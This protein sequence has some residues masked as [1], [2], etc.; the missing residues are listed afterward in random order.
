VEFFNSTGWAFYVQVAVRDLIKAINPR[1]NVTCIEGNILEPLPRD[2]VVG[3]DLVICCTD[4]NHSRTAVSELAYRYLVPAIDVGVVFESK[5][6]SI[7]GEIGRVTFYSPGGPCA[8]CLGL[9]DPWR[10]TVELMSEEEKDCRRREAKEA[11][12]RGDDADAYWRDNPEIPTVGHFTSVVGS[13]AASYAI[14][15][16]TGKFS[17]PNRYFE[18]NILA[19]K[20]DYIGFDAPRRSGCYCEM[21]VGHADQGA[22]ASLISAPSHWPE[23]R[24]V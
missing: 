7:T 17:P 2:H 5:S 10:A 18:F 15:W 1:A 22:H 14:G 16:L 11:K 20:F 6:G 12:L 24:T 23:A 9:V 8:H 19:P 21:L 13:L 4:T 3:T